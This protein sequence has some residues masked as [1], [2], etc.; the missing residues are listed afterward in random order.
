MFSI[1]IWGVHPFLR[2]F[3]FLTSPCSIPP[4][5]YYQYHYDQQVA[6]NQVQKT[7][8]YSACCSECGIPAA[9]VKAPPSLRQVFDNDLD[10]WLL[11]E[12][13]AAAGATESSSDA[14]ETRALSAGRAG[15]LAGW[16][17]SFFFTFLVLLLLRCVFFVSGPWW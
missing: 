10:P 3:I 15:W 6:R 9:D 1:S 8:W 17:E 12:T 2:A 13:A 5:Y 7:S 16:L 4:H 11:P 14:G